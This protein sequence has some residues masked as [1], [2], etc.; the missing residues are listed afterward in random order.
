MNFRRHDSLTTRLGERSGR[1]LWRLWVEDNGFER[2]RRNNFAPGTAFS[3]RRR[4]GTGLV[5]EET[6]IGSCHV[7]S[8][9][10]FGV[11]SYEA[12]D[13]GSFIGGPEVRVRIQVGRI[14]VA[15]LLRFHAV[16][17]PA[18]ERWVIAGGLVTTPGGEFE[19]RSAGPLRLPQTAATIEANLDERNLVF[20]TELIGNQRPGRVLVRGASVLLTVAG[21]FLRACGYGATGNPGEFSR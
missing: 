8:R 16:A 4:P 17:K 5:I 21:Q 1:N 6:L 14:V 19:L 18:A 2:L 7:S 12:S 11:L 9:R 10:G 15:P 3:V 20:A 13:L